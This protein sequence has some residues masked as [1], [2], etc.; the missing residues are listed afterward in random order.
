VIGV[1][2]CQ[3]SKG[4]ADPSRGAPQNRSL[5][6]LACGNPSRGDDALGPLLIE[7]LEALQRAGELDQVDLLVDFQLQIEHILDLQGRELVVFVDAAANGP[8]PFS[9]EPV[10]AEQEIGYTTHAMTPGALLRVFKQIRDEDPPAM[11]LLA[12][13][14][15]AFDLGSSISGLALEN[16]KKAIDHLLCLFRGEASRRE[17]D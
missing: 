3:S 9:F 11:R 14:G 4:E 6:V 15:Y 2:R 5:L 16:L 7:R 12:I 1:F 10:Q 8:E 17:G 13:R